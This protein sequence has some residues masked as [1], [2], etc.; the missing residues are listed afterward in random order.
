M[1]GL[2]FL[3]AILLVI[4]FGVVL[5]RALFDYR[6]KRELFQLHHAERMAAIEKGIEVPALPTEFFADPSRT[7]ER[8]LRR[9]LEWTLVGVALVIALWWTHS[10]DFQAVWGLL[11]TGFGLGNLL[12]YVIARRIGAI[13]P[14]NDAQKRD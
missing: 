4:A 9:G 2:I 10:D 3:I 11:P 5:V 1:S 14:P 6:R 12:Y 7:P 8:Y 13:R